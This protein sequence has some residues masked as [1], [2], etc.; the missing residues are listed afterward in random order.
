ML[1]RV[2]TPNNILDRVTRLEKRIASL[3]V[4]AVVVQGVETP[5]GGTQIRFGG[6][7]A[8]ETALTDLLGKAELSSGLPGVLLRGGAAGDIVLDGNAP[9]LRMGQATAYMTGVGV[10]MGKDGSVYKARIGNPSGEHLRFDGAG[11]SYTGAIAATSGTLGNLTV[12]GAL[13]VGA[14]TPNLVIDGA[15]KRIQSSNYAAGAAG[16]R[17]DGATGIA[18]FNDIGMRGEIRTTMIP[19]GHTLAAGGVIMANKAVGKLRADCNVSSF[20]TATID[21]ADPDGMSHA[22]FGALWEVNDII[23]LREPSVGVFWGRVTNK[24]DMGSYWRLSALWQSGVSSGTF[25]A[26]TTVVNYG[27]SGQGFIVMNSGAAEAPFFSLRTHA[28]SPWSATTE[29]M[30]IG[31]LKGNWGYSGDVYGVALGSFGL[32]NVSLT[33]DETDGLRIRRG[34]SL[35]LR[36]NNSGVGIFEGVFNIG[37]SGGI[38]QGTG[39]FAS[40]TTGLKIWNNGGIGEFALYA[41]GSRQVFSG[42][43]TLYAGTAGAVRLNGNSV[44]ILAGTSATS[45]QERAFKWLHD[46]GTPVVQE[47][48]PLQ[49]RLRR[50][51]R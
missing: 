10:W 11:M 23:R 8:T 4:G 1:E 22:N 49:R 19:R 15:N 50:R 34:R 36:V 38:F 21:I 51:S 45:P 37:F 18:E 33:V 5:T 3:E 12:T 9:S 7:I 31:N 17:I 13:T 26:G 30:R 46:I 29:L 32:T 27:K 47:L 25:R 20:S 39:T 44:S 43:G 48:T 35:V 42:N 14:S 16:F 28:G 2:L 41:S 24:T 40:P 6:W